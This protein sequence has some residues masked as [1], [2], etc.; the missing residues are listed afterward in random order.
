MKNVVLAGIILFLA[1][2]ANITPGEYFRQKGHPDLG[3]D[4]LV[5]LKVWGTTNGN[6]F[7]GG[8]KES[9]YMQVFFKEVGSQKYTWKTT[10]KKRH[11]VVKLPEG[12]WYIHA[13]SP[14]EILLGLPAAD[15]D[16]SSGMG[17]PFKPFT[18]K[19]GEMIYL[20]DVVLD[21]VKHEDV[22]YSHEVELTKLIDSFSEVTFSENS[23]EWISKYPNM[24]KQ[25]LEFR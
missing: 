8:W 12:T 18:V 2:C 15:L 6:L 20:G 11:S 22:I 7:T 19:A 9:N 13:V 24:Q 21:S 17:L 25:L 23:A 10:V 1:A 16:Y 5:A 3:T 4:G 14:G